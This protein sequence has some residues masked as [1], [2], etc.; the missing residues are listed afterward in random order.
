MARRVAGAAVKGVIGGM[1]ERGRGVILTISSVGADVCAPAGAPYY[2]AKAGV[3]A[4]T[5]VTFS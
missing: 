5:G 4:L 2:V 1:L 3:N